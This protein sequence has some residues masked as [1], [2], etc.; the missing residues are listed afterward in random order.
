MALSLQKVTI[1]DVVDGDCSPGASE[2]YSKRALGL[3][4]DISG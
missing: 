1:L 4:L 2:T 3:R